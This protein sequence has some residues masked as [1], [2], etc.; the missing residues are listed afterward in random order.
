MSELPS[1]LSVSPKQNDIKPEFAVTMQKT[2]R[3]ETVLSLFD[4][5]N[6]M[7]EDNKPDQNLP[8]LADVQYEI[9]ENK[10]SG[11]FNWRKK[12]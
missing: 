7:K 1:G 12:K 2:D 9:K 5:D 3:K 10:K 11:L 4:E 8:V 6:K